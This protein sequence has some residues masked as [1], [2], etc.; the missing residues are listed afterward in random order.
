MGGAAEFEF[1]IK[2]QDARFN[3]TYYFRL[4]DVTNSRALTLTTGKSYPSVATG[5]TSLSFT[6]A[7]LGSGVSTEGITTDVTTTSTSIPLGTLTAGTSVEAAQRLTVTTNAPQ[8]YQVYAYT[9]HGLTGK[10]STEIPVVS[11]TNAV[12]VAW[13]V[14]SGATGAFGYHAGQ[15]VLAGSS[16]RFTANDTYAQ[17]DTTAREI[18]YSSVPVTSGSSSDL[19][20]RVQITSLQQASIYSA[21]LSYIVVPTF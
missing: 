11:G 8:G 6:V 20:V 5:G 18:D 3:T 9:N 15:D 14:T 13:A 4:Y 1:T 7:G 17:F 2:N 10:S 12:P 16:T 21:T 19:V